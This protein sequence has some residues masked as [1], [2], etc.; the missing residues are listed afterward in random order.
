MVPTDQAVPIG[1]VVNELVT[2]ALKYAYPDD[3]G[4]PIRVTLRRNG[5]DAM[6]LEVMDQGVGLPAGFD[7]SAPTKSLG[8][9]LLVNTVRQINATVD[10]E[11]LDPG[12]RFAVAIPVGR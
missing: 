1:L 6:I 9:R 4:G 8:M 7:L 3:R 2:N 11:R 5:E 10:A 12:T